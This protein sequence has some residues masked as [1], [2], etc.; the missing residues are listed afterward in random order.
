MK[1]ASTISPLVLFFS[2]FFATL[3]VFNVWDHVQENRTSVLT[4]S[5]NGRRLHQRIMETD[6]ST[7]LH[8]EARS[9]QNAWAANANMK[10]GGQTAESDADQEFL[11]VVTSICGDEERYIK[12]IKA[13]VRSLF[14]SSRPIHF[15][16]IHDGD[17]RI[18]AELF[19]PLSKLVEA[20][21][22]G[23]RIR[24]S[25]VL[26]DVP[27][28]IQD[29]FTWSDAATSCEAA[30]L[31]LAEQFPDL[32][33][34]VAY[35]DPHVVIKRDIAEFFAVAQH[36]NAKQWMGLTDEAGNDWYTSGK[37]KGPFVAPNGLSGGI[38]LTHLGKWRRNQEFANFA[39]EYNGHMPLGVQDL[40]NA[41]FADRPDEVY[42]MPR[43]WNYRLKPFVDVPLQEVG[44][45]HGEADLFD[46]M[47][48]FKLREM[49]VLRSF[50]LVGWLE[51]LSSLA[52]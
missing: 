29:R 19:D 13:M 35:L 37:T 14:R 12:F 28:L 45:I 16:V 47:G 30:S 41:Y 46:R 23:R 21:L 36:W 50:E 49:P 17:A 31:R 26:R 9:K 43:E 6:P 8:K 42:V 48:D 10:Q 25:A 24:F 3:A 52:A 51:D 38:V 39:L 4:E 22:L 2:V 27:P 33:G 18:Q 34:L 1:Q 20:G 7:V 11:H 5:A 40:L 32:K 44:M 15:H